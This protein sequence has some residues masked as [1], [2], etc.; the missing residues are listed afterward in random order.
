MIN[1]KQI[2][3][4][5]KSEKGSIDKILVTLLLIIV[6]VAGIVGL[7]NWTTDQRTSIQTESKSA[8][9]NVINE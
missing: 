3:L 4:K 5:L 7:E 2:L 8:I 9:A 6:A 1:M